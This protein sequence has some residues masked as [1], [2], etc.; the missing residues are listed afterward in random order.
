M[1]KGQK[2]NFNAVFV[3]WGKVTTNIYILLERN[4][5]VGTLKY[6]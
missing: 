2:I 1:E 5:F 3:V 6:K 4:A